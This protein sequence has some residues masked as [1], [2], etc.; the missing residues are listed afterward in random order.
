MH[1]NS[2]GASTINYTQN[3]LHKVDISENN[4]AVIPTQTQQILCVEKVGIIYQTFKCLYIFY[5]II[6]L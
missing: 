4:F 5:N 3:Y 1:G 2:C 6:T